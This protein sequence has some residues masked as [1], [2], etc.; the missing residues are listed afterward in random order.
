MA[1]Y[2]NHVIYDLELEHFS[3]GKADKLFYRNL[4]T[5]FK[6]KEKYLPLPGKNISIEKG[7]LMKLT[8]RIIQNGFNTDETISEIS[9][10]A[11]IIGSQKSTKHLK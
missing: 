1:G 2:S 5:I 4:I 8:K 6:K 7:R 3:R 9:Y 10:F 11:R